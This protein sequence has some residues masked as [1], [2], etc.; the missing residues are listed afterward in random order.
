MH[1]VQPFSLQPLTSGASAWGAG[2]GI[3]QH[4]IKTPADMPPL[5]VKEDQQNRRGETFDAVQTAHPQDMVLVVKQQSAVSAEVVDF[6]SISEAAARLEEPGAL[7]A[8][9]ETFYHL[10]SSSDGLELGD[11]LTSVYGLG[12]AD[13]EGA[14]D[15]ELSFLNWDTLS[16]PLK[17]GFPAAKLKL[18]ERNSEGDTLSDLLAAS[19][20]VSVMYEADALGKE[21]KLR[22]FGSTSL[23]GERITS[24]TYG[25]GGRVG[26]LGYLSQKPGPR[27]EFQLD[28]VIGALMYERAAA[29]VGADTL[30]SDSD[31][32]S[33]VDLL[34]GISRVTSALTTV[35]GVPVS[36]LK[37]SS[38]MPS[39]IAV[40]DKGAQEVLDYMT[41]DHFKR[42]FDDVKHTGGFQ[43][44]YGRPVVA[45]GFAFDTELSDW[46][47]YAD[48]TLS[49]EKMDETFNLEPSPKPMPLSF[50][51]AHPLSGL[52][53]EF[54]VDGVAMFP[55]FSSDES[56]LVVS[57]L[58]RGESV[59]VGINFDS[60][61]VTVET[62]GAFSRRVAS[63]L[64]PY[65]GDIRLE[66]NDRLYTLHLDKERK[67]VV[68]TESDAWRSELD[69]SAELYLSWVKSDPSRPGGN[70]VALH[71]LSC[72][73]RNE[74][75]SLLARELRD[76][77]RELDKG[78]EDL[79]PPLKFCPL[80]G[81]DESDSTLVLPEFIRVVSSEGTAM[82]S[83]DE[84][85]AIRTR[86][87][88]DSD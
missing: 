18:S 56:R 88:I 86:A 83:F 3:Q 21:P 26:F 62:S 14:H 15:S 38:G 57:R 27:Y 9:D 5:K 39:V 78:D 55:R 29:G 12:S 74:S 20:R 31:S 69:M 51:V 87:R 11:S 33:D 66:G 19:E 72:Y 65:T 79:N 63:V 67:Q 48:S 32:D 54:V 34:A 68:A 43:S 52:N 35:T 23:M 2:A 85:S 84:Y 73:D 36:A 40:E 53:Q 71:N 28:S 16:V 64:D 76:K 47:T 37:E 7:L 80:P 70:R 75:R 77:I 42:V 25:T 30:F 58:L 6:M 13:A 60:S 17:E 22:D 24:P 59:S 44:L 4:S 8:E 82:I 61:A 50:S 41:V 81:S 45:R 10:I 46:G 1:R 49:V